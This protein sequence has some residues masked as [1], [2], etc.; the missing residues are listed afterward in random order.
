MV[1]PPVPKIWAERWGH[2]G[3][4]VLTPNGAGPWGVH[5]KRWTLVVLCLPAASFKHQL[6]QAPEQLQ[7]LENPVSPAPKL[8][9]DSLQS[10][11][12]FSGLI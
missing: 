9:F 6:H 3:E 4:A 5:R 10:R 7:S 2:P 1:V 11:R 12:F 8:D